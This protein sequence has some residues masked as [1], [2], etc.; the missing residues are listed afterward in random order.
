MDMAQLANKGTSID[1]APLL[2]LGDLT[3]SQLTDVRDAVINS[4]VEVGADLEDTEVVLGFMDGTFDHWA[5][6]EFCDDL[7]AKILDRSLGVV[8]LDV[9]KDGSVDV[10]DAFLVYEAKEDGQQHLFWLSTADL[11]GDGIVSEDD[12][13]KI[14]SA[15]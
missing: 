7:D 15:L 1:P 13:C 10:E 8:G 2:S 12:V 6:H 5:L 14:I 4:L 11:D 3:L 9:N